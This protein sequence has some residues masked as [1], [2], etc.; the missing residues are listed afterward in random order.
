[1]QPSVSSRREAIGIQKTALLEQSW[2]SCPHICT[3][4]P[5]PGR[6]VCV[7]QPVGPLAL[8]TGAV[9]H[10]YDT[11]LLAW[12]DQAAASPQKAVNW[13][14]SK[15]DQRDMPAWGS[16]PLQQRYLLA[17]LAAKPLEDL[18]FATVLSNLH[19]QAQDKVAAAQLQE[20]AASNSGRTGLSL[21]SLM[22]K[23]LRTASDVL[24]WQADCLGII[25]REHQHRGS[26]G[27]KA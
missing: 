27:P 17:L 14:S 16:L 25:L 10:G 4:R 2:F 1:M 19:Q 12:A 13:I 7:L 20:H 23:Q 11:S 9:I 26:G 15:G 8:Q 6:V 18:P 3:L 21:S 24:L 5:R 22:A